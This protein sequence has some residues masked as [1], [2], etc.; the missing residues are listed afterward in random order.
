MP[1]V[2]R[3]AS[4]EEVGGAR[5]SAQDPLD[6]AGKGCRIR[7]MSSVDQAEKAVRELSANQLAEFRRWFLEFDA[8]VWDAEFEE[9]ASSGKLDRLGEK[10][11]EDVRSGRSRPL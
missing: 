11:L 4:L 5:R 1:V 6:G 9:D 3:L 8:E 7:P 2:P 10:A